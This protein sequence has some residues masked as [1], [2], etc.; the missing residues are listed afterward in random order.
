MS[1]SGYSDDGEYISLWRGTVASAIRG[2]RGQA[3]LREMLDAMDALPE[4]R[5][6]SFALEAEGQYCALGT[7]GA[8]RGVDMGKLDPEDYDGVAAA[9]GIASPLAQEIFWIN[10]EAEW[11]PETPEQRFDRVRRWIVKNLREATP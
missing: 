9:F 8:K 6:V 2:K 4:K 3:L 11:R 10:D 1:R 5:L 7:V